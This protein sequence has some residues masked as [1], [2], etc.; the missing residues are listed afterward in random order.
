MFEA[1]SI[2]RI[3]DLY[4]DLYGVESGDAL[5]PS[6]RRRIRIGLVEGDMLVREGLVALLNTVEEFECVGAWKQIADSLAALQRLCP[7][8]LLVDIRELQTSGLMLFE[9]LPSLNPSTC[10]LLMT[11]CQEHPPADVSVPAPPFHGGTL[12]QLPGLRFERCDIVYKKCGF[13]SIV[14]HI[15]NASAGAHGVDPA[16]ITFPA[17]PCFPV[18]QHNP[19]AEKVRSDSLTSREWQVIHMIGLGHSNKHIAHAMQLNYSTVKNYV[20]SILKK[21]QLEGRTQ[22]ALLAHQWSG[23]LRL[24]LH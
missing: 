15:R 23:E 19:T 5:L 12:P 3:N 22:I 18:T 6:P 1:S 13:L 10:V 17:E 7:D 24:P 20:S 16:G 4:G 9:T 21:L 14:V 11:N 2:Q 8:V